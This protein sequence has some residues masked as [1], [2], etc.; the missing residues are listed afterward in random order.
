MSDIPRG[1]S[2][3]LWTTLR[4]LLESCA[5]AGAAQVLDCGGGSGSLAVP[6]ASRGAEVTVVDVSIDALGTLVR[7]ASEAGV[8]DRVTAL[9]GEVESLTELVADRTFDLVLAHEVL[10][11]VLS[12]PAAFAEITAATRPGGAIS[13]VVA[14]PVAVV[15]GRALAG[16]VT[17]ALNAL[18]RSA[19]ETL[20]LPSLEE[21]CRSAGL[22]V[23]RIDGIGV[24]SEIVP[25]IELERPGAM[26]ALAELEAATSSRAPYRDIAARLH[27][28]AR[29]PEIPGRPDRT[30]S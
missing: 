23:E 26:T 1:Q 3:Q 14:N 15:L 17:G 29:R 21:L 20:S 10:E 27:V 13:V 7:R 6:L 5:G 25:G 18:T 28:I 22:A 16:D 8:S 19:A 4:G 2:P 9:Q 24:F 12:L 11:N 30:D